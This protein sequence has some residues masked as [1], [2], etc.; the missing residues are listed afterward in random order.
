MTT[1]LVAVIIAALLFDFV[2]GW[3][4][5][6]NAIA[7]VVSTRVLA[8]ITAV[9]FAAVLNVAGAFVSTRVA[10][11][12]GS[13]LVDPTQI[14]PDVVVASMLAATVWVA[15]CTRWGLPISGSHSLI[16]SLVGAAVAAFG[17]G[18]LYPK[19]LLTVLLA[20][21][22]SPVLGM[23]VG[24]VFLVGVYWIASGMRP[25]TVRRVFGI[26]QIGS[27]GFMAFT[28]GMN[29]AQKV[30]GVITLALFAAGRIP[31]VVV[32]VWV[33]F[34]CAAA[35]GLGTACG[36]WR[37]IRTLGS[38]LTHIRPIE[39]FAAET[40][41]GLVLSGAASLGVPVSTTHTITGAI[42]GI[43]TA[44]RARSVKWGMGG[45]I[46]YAWV[47]TLPVTALLAAAV[48]LLLRAA[49]HP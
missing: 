19:G 26:A 23:I 36:G 16:G 12:I 7:T 47:L 9:L 48:S 10:K 33:I 30:M 40:A 39:G 3:N 46:L 45:K 43:G 15:A 1:M 13:G 37:V 22:A 14:T 11:T 8:P 44:Y 18:V 41:G 38:R 21:V 42:L 2:N 49:L 5:S 28:H 25:T 6:A 4:D 32:P 35:M 34:L 17:P 27:S 20:L 29:D 31:E 24:Y